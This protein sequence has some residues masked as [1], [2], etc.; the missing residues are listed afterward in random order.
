MSKLRLTVMS[1]LRDVIAGQ[2]PLGGDNETMMEFLL[3]K[4]EKTHG[5]TSSG[6]KV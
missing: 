3:K 4:L 5:G 6:L 1:I 2:N